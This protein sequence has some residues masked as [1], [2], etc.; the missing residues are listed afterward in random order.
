[1]LVVGAAVVVIMGAQEEP[2][3]VVQE[4]AAII[5]LGI[6]REMVAQTLV[7]A[8]VVTEVITPHLMAGLA[9]LGSL[10]YVVW[11]Q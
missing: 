9:V 7:V 8:V 4:V 6:N 3:A 11:I 5:P 10:L 1:M 2:G